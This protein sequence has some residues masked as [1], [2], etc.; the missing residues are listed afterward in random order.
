MP[1]IWQV[2]LKAEETPKQGAEIQLSPEDS[3]H[4]LNV[5]RRRSGDTIHVVDTVSN[6]KFL[7]EV[8]VVDKECTVKLLEEIQTDKNRCPVKKLCFALCKGKKNELVC[9]KATEL[10]VR[11]IVFWTSDR[12]V[13]TGKSEQWLTRLRK[14]AESAAKQ[15]K[16]SAIPKVSLETQ[17]A[18]MLAQLNPKNTLVCS[19]KESALP[20][21]AY[22]DIL[23]EI[24][25]IIGPEGD[26]SPEE[27]KAFTERGFKLVSIGDY[28][29]RSETAAITAIAMVNAL[30]L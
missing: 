3:H 8:Q 9:E 24:N 26:F 6:L 1:Q 29:L 7:A 15:S 20:L 30:T 5:I 16:R 11:E 12:S 25:L 22:R 28:P 18:E 4:V 17:F 27:E 23:S 10:G 13:T 14:V 19:L 21:P 2:F